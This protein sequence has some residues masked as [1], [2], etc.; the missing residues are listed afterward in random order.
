MN[1]K[2]CLLILSTLTFTTLFASASVYVIPEPV[3][4][5]EGKGYFNMAKVAKVDCAD[6]SLLR[7][8][9]IFA[10]DMNTVLGVQPSVAVSN[11]GNISLSLRFK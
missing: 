1:L 11:G 8:A 7:G 5:Q 4:V 10:E 6:E 9:E 2:R 3:S